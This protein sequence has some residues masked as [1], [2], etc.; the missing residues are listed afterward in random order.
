MALIRIFVMYPAG[1][2]STW[3]VS[4]DGADGSSHSDGLLAIQAAVERAQAL[5]QLGHEVIVKQEGADG[6][7]Q[8][9]RE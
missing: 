4:V 6:S 8:I 5:E 2:T 3:H 7:W 1:T 9:L